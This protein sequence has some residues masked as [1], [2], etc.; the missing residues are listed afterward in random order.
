MVIELNL[1][2]SRGKLAK[3]AEFPSLSVSTQYVYNWFYSSGDF[4][5]FVLGLTFYNIVIGMNKNEYIHLPSSGNSFDQNCCMSD[6]PW[7]RWVQD[8]NLLEVYFVVL[9]FLALSSVILFEFFRIF[10]TW[11]SIVPET[12]LH[13]GIQTK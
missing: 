6:I 13:L 12:F 7:C 3:S 4:I 11:V 10:L 1:K 8:W 5:Q 9:G 2:I